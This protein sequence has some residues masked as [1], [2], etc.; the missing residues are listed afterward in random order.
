MKIPVLIK[1]IEAAGLIG[2]GCNSFPTAKKWQ[3]VLAA[4]VK[5][6]YVICNC[7][8]SEPGFFKDE[9][10]LDSYPERVLDGVKLAMQTLKAS[11]GFIYL[12]PRYYNRLHHKIQVLIGDDKIEVFSKPAD[13]YVGGEE[14]ALI[15]LM[16]GKREEPRLRPPFVTT[17]GFLGQP[18]LVNNCE[19]F[20]T[21]SLINE[22]K[23]NHQRFFCISGDNTPR[24]VFVLPEKL[25]IQQA[26][27][28]TG[29][30]PNFPFFIQL[31]GAAAGTCLRQNQL[32]NYTLE[33]YAGLVVHSLDKDEKE[34]IGYWLNFFANESCGKCVPCREGTYRL[35]EMY[36]SKKYD[37]QLFADIIYS[38]QNTSFC[39]LGKMATSA[40]SSYYQ[41]I[42]RQPLQITDSNINKCDI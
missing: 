40:I 34:L 1:K 21:V 26:L 14:T 10:I 17:Q 37:P 5:D 33:R 19:T 7:S 20:Y 23:Y 11:K 22:G 9:F 2:R 3:L 15:N 4:K 42:K 35:L 29:H 6:K 38:M 18:T 27:I 12:N 41:N 13:D 28:Q 31:G 32:E 25:N 39:S 24:G 8:E 30:Y 36:N 16:E